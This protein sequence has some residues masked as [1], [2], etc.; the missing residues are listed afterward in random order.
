MLVVIRISGMVKIPKKIEETLKRLRLRRKYVAVVMDDTPANRK[1]LVKIRNYIAYGD[2]SKEILEKLISLRGVTQDKNM[3][4]KVDAK[5]VVLNL[6]KK[7]LED[8]GFKPFFRLH[9][10]RGGIE[11]KKHAGVGKGV[12]GDNKEKINKL[13]ERML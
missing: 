5:K 13:V 2:I 8:Q 1:L 11:S 4:D 7:N 6:E 12:L 10:P 3:M 9:P